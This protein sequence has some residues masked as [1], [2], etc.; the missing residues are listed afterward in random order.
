[1]K[2]IVTEKNNVAQ[3]IAKLVGAGKGKAD[4]VYSTP[5]YR[6]EMDGEEAVI[7]G[8]RGH[9]L[10][11]DFAARLEYKKS[12]GWKGIDSDGRQLEAHLPRNLAK[13]PYKTK[14]K[15]FRPDGIDLKGASRSLL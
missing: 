10:E 4:K 6:C 2:L 8:L 3:N 7:I 9:I 13:P 11:P 12:R 15:P 14:R 1:M 5:V